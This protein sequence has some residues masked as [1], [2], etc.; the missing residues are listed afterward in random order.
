MNISTE[1]K[2]F[3]LTILSAPWVY[4]TNNYIKILQ[5][6]FRI[7]IE[8]I[9]IDT[10]PDMADKYRITVLPTILVEDTDKEVLR[11]TGFTD[12]S[13]MHKALKELGIS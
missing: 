9:N 12:V 6:S 4:G 11:F 8:E 13:T 1:S 5:D 2:S 3:T 7:S 10:R